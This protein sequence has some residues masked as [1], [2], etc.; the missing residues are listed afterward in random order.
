M[1]ARQ[2]VHGKFSD[3]FPC[4]SCTSTPATR[5]DEWKPVGCA[6][7]GCTDFRREPRAC[8]W[9]ER[10]GLGRLHWETGDVYLCTK[11]S[12]LLDPPPEIAKRMKAEIVL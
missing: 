3:Q 1:A 11:C 12:E 4:P 2:C 6:K 9:I 7:C 8:V 10:V 5:P